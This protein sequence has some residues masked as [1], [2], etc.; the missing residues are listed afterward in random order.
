MAFNRGILTVLRV[1]SAPG[2]W[3]LDWI[4][5]RRCRNLRLGLPRAN[6]SMQRS[7]GRVWSLVFN[8]EDAPVLPA[9]SPIDV[10]V[11]GMLE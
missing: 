10:I 2:K 7:G 3:D 9:C 6:V 4:G 11:D 1:V 5:F 8:G